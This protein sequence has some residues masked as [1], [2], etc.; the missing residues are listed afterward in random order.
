[1]ITTLEESLS[2]GDARLATITKL[3]A[4]LAK[5]EDRLSESGKLN[6]VLNDK[7]AKAEMDN[8]N[9]TSRLKTAEEEKAGQKTVLCEVRTEL[10]EKKNRLKEIEELELLQ[11]R[12]DNEALKERLA[13]AETDLAVERSK[14][15]QLSVDYEE[16]KESSQSRWMN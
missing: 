3:E 10:E 9:V 13:K 1:M 8:A 6:G 7:L 12:A 11:V 2:R 16:E 15:S 5:V 4:S 14:S